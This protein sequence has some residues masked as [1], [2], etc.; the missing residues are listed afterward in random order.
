[1]KS[2][3]KSTEAGKAVA[4]EL[5]KTDNDALTKEFKDITKG[6]K[7]YGQ[8]D[9]PPVSDACRMHEYMA[10]VNDK[11]G[12]ATKYDDGEETAWVDTVKHL[13]TS[14]ESLMK[15]RNPL[16]VYDGENASLA[17]S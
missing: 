3:L 4:S 16:Y 2:A 6:L 10:Q 11:V 12:T 1:M 8:I 15:L 13:D 14:K 9:F 5:M 17:I 7:S